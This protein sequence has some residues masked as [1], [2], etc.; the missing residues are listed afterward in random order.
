MRGA[1]SEGRMAQ[2]IEGNSWPQRERGRMDGGPQGES[3]IVLLEVRM[4]PRKLKIPPSA[5]L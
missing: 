2:G 3:L 5:T 4:V 1:A